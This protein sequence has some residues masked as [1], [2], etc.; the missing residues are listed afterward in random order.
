MAGPSKILSTGQCARGG[1]QLSG[2]NQRTRWV[3]YASFVQFEPR[4]AGERPDETR[5]GGV[6]QVFGILL[7]TARRTTR[8]L[9]THSLP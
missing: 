6:A 5:G 3:I 2:H 7:K 1:N 4:L 9:S 8:R